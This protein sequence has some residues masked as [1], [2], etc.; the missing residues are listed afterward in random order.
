MAIHRIHSKAMAHLDKAR[1]LA[2]KGD[3]DSL[4]YA[5]LELRFAVERIVLDVLKTYE[6]QGEIPDEALTE[7]RLKE[8]LK[9]LWD[10]NPDLPQSVSFRIGSEGDS[11]PLSGLFLTGTQSGIDAAAL[12]GDW[13][14]LGKF[15][16]AERGEGIH[17][18]QDMQRAIGSAVARLEPY[19]ND[20]ALIN[21]AERGHFTCACGRTVTRR[22]SA[23]KKDPVVR[24]PN[25]ACRAEYRWSG[26]VSDSFFTPVTVEL[27]CPSC[28]ATS[29]IGRHLV[30][31][32]ARLHCPACSARLSIRREYF[33]VVEEEEEI[34][35]TPPAPESHEEKGRE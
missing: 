20:T 25:K 29:R 17:P 2:E 3:Y 19:R 32:R 27:T 26:S 21:A 12:G 11:G 8:I 16:H 1:V 14:L 28:T 4:R 5:A 23:L 7:W 31:D 22:L 33:A 35:P 10:C 6:N 18:V 34:A 15:L 13:K 30:R 24:C 9:I